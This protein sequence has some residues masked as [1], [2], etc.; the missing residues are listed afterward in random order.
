[1]RSWKAILVALAA[2]VAVAAGAG[3]VYARHAVMIGAGYVAKLTCSCVY[4]AGRDLEACRADFPP[5]MDGIEASLLPGAAGVRTEASLLGVERIAAHAEG[6]G[7]RLLPE[8][9]SGLADWDR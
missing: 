7:C 1:M 4:V 6:E 9:T 5:Y 2:A 8:G 3:L